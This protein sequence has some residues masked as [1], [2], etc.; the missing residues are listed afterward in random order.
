MRNVFEHKKFWSGPNTKSFQEN[1]LKGNSMLSRC[2][3]LVVNGRPRRKHRNS[4]IHLVKR[5]SNTIASMHVVKN[6]SE[7]CI[8]IVS[9][10]FTIYLIQ[11]PS[12]TW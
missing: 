3:N 6:I 2:D 11:L 4:M 7:K 1:I 5:G 9:S 12:K 8:R 10:R